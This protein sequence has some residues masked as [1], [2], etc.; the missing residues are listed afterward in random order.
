MAVTF[1]EYLEF[2]NTSSVFNP[3]AK[4]DFL[5]HD[6]TV[7]A[8]FSSEVTG[9]SLSVTRANGVRRSCN[10]NVHNIYNT[11]TPNPLTFWINQKFR[12]SLG[13]HINGE[14]YFIPQGVFGL[15]NPQNIH[16]KSQREA[17]ISGTDKFA[18]LNGQL[19]GRLSATYS[20]PLGSNILDSIKVIL[21]ES[22]VND[23]VTPMLLI[24][25]SEETPYTIYQEYGST[26]G[27]LA[28]E[29][30][31]IISQNMYYNNAG[32]LVCEPDV[33]N[34]LKDSKWDFRTDS[35]VY[36]GMTQ[37]SNFNEAYNVVLVVGDNVNGN[38]AIGI[39]RN[40][41]PSSSLSTHRIGEKLAPPITDTVIDTD[42]RA[43]DRANFEI[44]RYAALATDNTITC[45]P[46]F[47][48]DVDQIIT[49]T[50]E[51]LGLNKERLLINNFSIPLN[52]NGAQSMTISATK[53]NDIDF[54]ITN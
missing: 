26:F 7:Y 39:A 38:L 41:D 12:L 50:D 30:N 21:L 53:A 43:Q 54:E 18:F 3:I 5:N 11:F 48:L 32:R 31:N 29:L 23:P 33:L 17:T 49:V 45:I 51:Q 24:D 13:Y 1:A 40:D 19:G 25:P 46:M 42:E 52:P 9:G 37:D 47:H 44:R 28:L 20:L 22:A 35:K 8:S 36:L 15:S 34:S 2:M 6:E 16:I 14:D 27:D 10:I 4:F